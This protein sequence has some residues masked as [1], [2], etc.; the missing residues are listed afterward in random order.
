M[1]Y[2]FGI[3]GG[4]TNSRLRIESLEGKFIFGCRGGSTNIYSNSAVS[5]ESSLSALFAKAFSEGG[6]A[7]EDCA[8]GFAGSAGVDR[9]RDVGLF[10]DMLLKASGLSC[11]VGSGNDAEPALVG[12]IGDTEGFLLNAGTGSIAYARARSGRSARAGGW[13][14]I[15]GDEGSAYRIAFDALSRGLRSMEER[16]L[17]TGLLD[18][19]LPFFGLREPSDLLTLTFGGADK[20]RIASFAGTV[21]E[22][23]DRGDPLAADIFATAARELESLALS[24]Y[25]RL[26]GEISRKRLAFAGGLLE[27]D[28][29]LKRLVAG[30]LQ[31]SAPDIEIVSPKADAATGACALAR[32][33]LS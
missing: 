14:H 2:V 10:T 8:A 13:G 12:A 29:E 30:R 20:T 7:P 16:D 6:L 22:Y 15:L 32:S 21:G 11:P 24:V 18:A 19:A 23:R 9:P 33:L 4:G 27:K 26:G 31:D 5:V 1:K 3:D 28:A 25:R 17:P